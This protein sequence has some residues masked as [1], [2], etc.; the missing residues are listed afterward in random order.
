MPSLLNVAECQNEKLESATAS[1]RFGLRGVADVEQQ[2]VAAARAAGEA[3]GRID[4][5]VVALRR[6]GRAPLAATG[7]ARQPRRVAPR[8]SRGARALRLASV[9]G[10]L[11]RDAAARARSWK[12][13]GELTIAACSGCASGTLMTSM[14]NSAMFGSSSGAASE[15][16]GSSLGERTPRRAGDVDVDVVL[17]VRVGHDACACA[18]RG[19]S[20][21]S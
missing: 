16:P 15:Q 19:R 8:R 5:D 9:G 7:P 6:A 12:M 21:R 1:M 3:D 20:A 4:R 18:S 11:R 13:R 14:R 10:D 17:V 2:A